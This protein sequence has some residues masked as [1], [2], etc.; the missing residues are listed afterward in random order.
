[1]QSSLQVADMLSDKC[2]RQWT[3]LLGI[4]IANTDWS[5]AAPAE[6][7]LE[8]LLRLP[9]NPLNAALQHMLAFKPPDQALTT[10]PPALHSSIIGAMITADGTLRHCP[11]RAS[12]SGVAAAQS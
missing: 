3:R 4:R 6:E 9:A 8:Q 12:N 1:M 10:L 7:M 5:A 11:P 2:M